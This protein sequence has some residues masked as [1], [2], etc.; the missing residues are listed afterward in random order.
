MTTSR[1]TAPRPA[2][3]APIHHLAE[4]HAWHEALRTG[5]YR[6]STLGRSLDDEGFVHCSSAAQLAGVLG[7]YYADHDRDL[8]LLTIDPARLTAPLEWEAADPGTGEEFPHVYGPIT[9]DAVVA[10]R[11]LRPPHAAPPESI[12]LRANGIELEVVTA[13]AAVRRLRIGPPETAVDV[14]LGHADPMTYRFA[15][16]YLG[17]VVGRVANRLAGGR[18]TVDGADH[19]VAT[20]EH[21][22]ILHGGFEGFDR[23]PWGVESVGSSHVR[24]ALTS[25]DGDNGFPGRVDVT[26][27]YTVSPGEVRIEYTARSDRPTPF[28]VTNHAY[29]N[30]DG[31]GSG[32]VDDHVLEVTASAFT[33]VG[34]DLLPTGEVRPVDGTP[35]DLRTPRR[36]GDL[37]AVDDEQL[38]H[39]RGLDHNL[40]LDGDGDGLRLAAR[41][42]GASGRVLEVHTDRP[43]LQVYTG[44]HFDGTTTGLSGGTYGPRAGIALETQAFPDAP[45]HLAFPDIT[46]RPEVP[47]RSTTV[48]R[49]RTD[50]GG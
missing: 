41:L 11:V 34:A 14:V 22:T 20:N 4:P 15:G 10:T 42:R 27:A 39:G 13:G 31:E 8:V 48:W 28:N 17:A 49:L 16:G 35:F 23:M 12:T 32:P 3:T 47:F 36:I 50:R 2:G 25:P 21:G 6:W 44:A 1:R 24:L 7:R 5:E 45:N 9:P 33:P 29:V 40:V 38:R 43:G 18:F 26:V 37:L 30:L 19:A 46:L